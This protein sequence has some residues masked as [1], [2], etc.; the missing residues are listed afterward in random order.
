MTRCQVNNPRALNFETAAE[1]AKIYSACFSIR[2]AKE[3]NLHLEM[4][5]RIKDN[6]GIWIQTL[7]ISEYN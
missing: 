5:L 6:Y 7:D 2:P 4:Y 1:I 3:T